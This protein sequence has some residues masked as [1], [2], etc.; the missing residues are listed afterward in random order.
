MGGAAAPL[1]FFVRGAAPPPAIRWSLLL[2]YLRAV[3]A[4]RPGRMA[5]P[6]VPARGYRPSACPLRRPYGRPRDQ[7]EC[8]GMKIARLA[9][10]APRRALAPGGW[11]SSGPGGVGPGPPWAVAGLPRSVFAAAR[12]AGGA[13]PPARLKAALGAGPGGS[14]GRPPCGLAVPPVAAVWSLGAFLPP[15]VGRAALGLPWPV[16]AWGAVIGWPGAPQRPGG[17]DG[18]GP[19]SGARAVVLF[20][21]VPCR[22]RSG[23]RF[24]GRAGQRWKKAVRCPARGGSAAAAAG[25]GPGAKPPDGGLQTK[26]THD[27]F[28]S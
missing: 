22:R 5:R 21:L 19:L 18:R 23:P 26:D 7:K 14:A 25:N 24:S 3:R 28:L 12:S 2:P 13:A 27:G 1:F 9:R 17:R 16:P 4:A 20:G 8:G 6:A 10:A 15:R 11:W